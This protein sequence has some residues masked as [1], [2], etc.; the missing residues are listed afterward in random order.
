MSKMS[1]YWVIS[2]PYFLVFGL[3]TGKYR[4]EIIFSLL[5]SIGICLRG[6]RSIRENEDIVKSI[7]NNA[8]VS[9]GLMKIVF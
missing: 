6:S 3:N 5:Q 2:G 7:G 8:V 4:P 9:E 1:K